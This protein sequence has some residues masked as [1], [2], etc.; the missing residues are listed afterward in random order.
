MEKLNVLR[1]LSWTIIFNDS[2][3]LNLILTFELFT[4]IIFIFYYKENDVQNKD[5][6][7]KKL[8]NQTKC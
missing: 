8:C 7:T 1:Y 2:Y 4:Q 6:K 5:V 3:I